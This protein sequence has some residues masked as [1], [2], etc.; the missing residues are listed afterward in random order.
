MKA[1]GMVEVYSF[2]TAVAA[3]DAAAKAADRLLSI[4]GVCASFV[5]CTIGNEVSISARSDGN[6]NVQ[7]VLEALG[8]GGHFDAAGAQLK[9]TGMKEA[10]RKLKLA[11]DNYLNAA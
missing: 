7:L 11:I 4:E 2:S 6:V 1:L 5:L 10:L 8:G 9:E 3:A